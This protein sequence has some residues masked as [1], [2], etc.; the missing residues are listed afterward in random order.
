MYAVIFKAEIHQ[1]DDMYSQMAEQLRKLATEKYGCIDFISVN[2]GN[3]EVAISY[4]EKEEHIR[5]WKQDIEHIVAQKHGRSKWY[6]SY[7]VQVVEV[8]RE[9]SQE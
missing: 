7:Q 2:E 3:R 1:L 4:W 9:Y 8:L 6:K 5:L